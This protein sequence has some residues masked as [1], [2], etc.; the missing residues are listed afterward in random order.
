MGRGDWSYVNLPKL[1]LRRLDKFVES[2]QAR[3]YGVFNKSELVRKLVN[4]FLIEQ[5]DHYN[6]ME[7]IEEFINEIEFGDHFAITFNDEKQFQEI[8]YAYVRRGL[9]T[10]AMNVL[11]ISK[12]D[13][14][15]FLNALR[16]IKNI[17]SL[18]NSHKV[19]MIYRD[20][21][22]KEGS[23]LLGKPI[24]KTIEDFIESAK[25]KSMKGIY[26]LG[27]FAGRLV[28]EGNFEEALSIERV[29]HENNEKN[30]CTM[31]LY[32]S[33]SEKLEEQLAGLH[34]LII[35]RA[36]TKTGLQ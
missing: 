26:I 3:K 31:C 35:K 2:P 20:E 28:E 13:E 7:S 9:A 14:M 12:K 1:L 30:I 34:H 5:E 23:F 8:V 27:Y 21:D 6:N 19:N 32:H 36:V 33:I 15:Q 22:S 17:D 29:W 11:I 16:K 4:E 10:N 18:F 25:R 24:L